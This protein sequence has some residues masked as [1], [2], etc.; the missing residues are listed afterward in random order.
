MRVGP[1]YSGSLLA[2]IL[3]AGLGVGFALLSKSTDISIAAIATWGGA[4]V[5]AWL[6]WTVLRQRSAVGFVFT[7]GFLVF[8][9]AGA[10]FYAPTTEEFQ[11]IN[12]LP[13]LTATQTPSYKY[14]LI[15]LVAGVACFL[16]A[17]LGSRRHRRS[18]NTLTSY[19]HLELPNWLILAAVIP[20]LIHIYGVGLS[21]LFHAERYL[22]HSGPSA[23]LS[24]GQALGPVG[25]LICGY[26]TFR[27]EAPV[28]IRISSLTLALCYEVAYF[29]IGTRLFAIWIPLMFAGGLLS[30]AWTTSRQRL[31]LIITI[32]LTLL[33]VQVPLGLR[34]Q[35]RHGVAASWHYL[36]NEPKVVFGNYDPLNNVLFGAPLTVYVGEA[37]SAIP[38]ADLLTATTPLPS[39]FTNWDEIRESL[40]VNIR[41]PYSAVGELLNFGWVYLFVVLFLVSA[42]F[43]YLGEVAGRRQNLIG[44]ACTMILLGATALFIVQA[45]EYNLRSVCRTFYYTAFLVI[46]VLAVT[47]RGR[48]RL[49]SSTGKTR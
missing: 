2:V 11:G 36:V 34:V 19:L 8:G 33:A 45:T 42:V 9:A 7:V 44:G 18:A 3:A 14:L 23:A 49:V 20:L 13:A 10:L 6:A 21:T 32:V 22:E 41:V 5:T 38:H 28:G 17:I 39:G 27:K 16:G 46:I 24:V 15:F 29:G 40:R 1:I 31:Y 4:L 43:S 12:A 25:V 35:P 48:R 37:V 47:R 26:F 30:G